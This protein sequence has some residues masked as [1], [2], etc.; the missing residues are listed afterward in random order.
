MIEA[1][2]GKGGKGRGATKPYLISTRGRGKR[3]D[4]GLSLRRGVRKGRKSMKPFHSRKRGKG[5]TIS[6]P[7][8]LGEKGEREGHLHHSLSTSADRRL[9]N[10]VEE[11]EE[12]GV[13]K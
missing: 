4:R 5:N 13:K 1:V 10:F 3:T 11:R 12:K 7:T 8:S 6:V 2:R 9:L